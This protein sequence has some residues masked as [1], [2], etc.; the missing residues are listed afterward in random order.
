M[1]IWQKLKSLFVKPEPPPAIALRTFVGDAT[2]PWVVVIDGDDARIIP[3]QGRKL[4]ASWFGGNDDPLDNG[5]TASG[6]L[7]KG[8]PMLKGCSLPM[9]I[10]N[11]H[12]VKSCHG[13]PIQN[14]PWRTIVKVRKGDKTI[15]IPLI[16]VGPAKYAGEVLDLTQAAFAE[17]AAKKAGI[18]S[19]DEITIIGGAKMF[20]AFV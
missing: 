20:G 7:T 18:V 17:F 2:W 11:K 1:T 3:R 15:S 10:S 14:L 19:V 16:D 5:E 9:R 8:N 13:S 12:T 4:S 6:I